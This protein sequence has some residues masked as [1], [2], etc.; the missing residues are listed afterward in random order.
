MSAAVSQDIRA[1]SLRTVYEQHHAFV[2][3]SLLRLGVPRA[4]VE[5]ALQ[6]VFIVVARRMS[7][8]E[9]RSRFESWLFGIAIRVAQR[10]RRTGFRA[11][12][13]HEALAAH[14]SAQAVVDEERRRE[15]AD[16]LHHL[17][18]CLPETERPIFVLSALE[19]Y[20]AKELAHDF[21]L[22]EAAVQGR[23][24]KAKKRLEKARRRLEAQDE[25]NRT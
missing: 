6:D 4:D 9:G 12:R 13:K 20:T 19:G 5:D 10:R 8:F 23:L 3:R 24:R 16:L 21:G 14:G 11:G 18:D 15:A 22:T 2:W 1:D 25:R 7:E 17:L